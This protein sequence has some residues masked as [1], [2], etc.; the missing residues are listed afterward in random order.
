MTNC[1]LAQL[2]GDSGLTAGCRPGLGLG[3]RAGVRQA[4]R[5]VAI[6]ALGL[7]G[8]TSFPSTAGWATA[9]EPDVRRDAAVQAV[10]R[11]L[12]SIV[13]I[14]TETVVEVRDPLDD[15]FRD[16]FG[17]YYRRRPPNAQKSLG[18]GVIIDEAGYILTNSHVVRRATRIT[19]TLA[20]GREFEAKELSQTDK[21]DVALLK[22]VTRS[23]DQFKAI[24]FASDD[25]LLL[26]ETVLALGNPF[27]L[28]VS[29]SRGILSSKTRRPSVEGESLEMED[30]L[31]TDAAINPGNSGGPLVNLRG[32]LI[33]LNVAVF[34]EGQGIGFAIPVKRLSEAVSEIFTP[35]QI[36]GF[37]LGARFKMATAGVVT[38]AV[39]PGS[40]AEKAGLRI[41]DIV[42][43]VNDRAARTPIEVNREIISVGD[44]REFQ[45]Q[46]QRQGERR[47]LTVRLVPEK[48][49]FN[50]SLIRQKLGVTAQELSTEMAAQLGLTSTDGLLISA[51]EKN[52]PAARA[53]LAR[54][55]VIRTI[56]G[57]SPA[58]IPA[59]AKLLYSRK[60]GETV[61]L[62]LVVSR[63]RG[64]FLEVYPAKVGVTLR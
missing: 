42:L 18:S 63:L 9:A 27:G 58:G 31:Q 12:P 19:V 46:V 41:G 44:A 45:L 3:H 20:D 60:P 14:S 36:R 26:G 15:L 51:V 49:V 30:W 59:A 57:A 1:V 10:E 25:D 47:T 61:E 62:G 22:L 17:P 16:F 38:G 24:K 8:L 11:V 48:E 2:W 29:V 6:A 7:L 4:G 39:E 32:E 37:W 21:S 53:N 28:G 34:R 52:S 50:A 5:S 55:Y 33:G 35:E 13:N 43:R 56:D 54:G 40:P 23:G 64:G